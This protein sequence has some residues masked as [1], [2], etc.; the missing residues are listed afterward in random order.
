MKNG[1][2]LEAE[3]R[4]SNAL[5][6]GGR[7]PPVHAVG[8][9]PAVPPRQDGPRTGAGPTRAAEKALPQRAARRC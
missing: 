5:P 9:G 3:N 1:I 2:L 4:R 8:S 7:F 6:S